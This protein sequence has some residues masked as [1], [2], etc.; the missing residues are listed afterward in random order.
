MTSYFAAWRELTERW[1]ALDASV[2][3]GDVTLTAEQSEE[4]A[5]VSDAMAM[6]TQ[7]PRATGFPNRWV[8]ARKVRN[9]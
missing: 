7:T 3:R 1:N 9:R 8:I 2:Q 6:A 4:L 5:A